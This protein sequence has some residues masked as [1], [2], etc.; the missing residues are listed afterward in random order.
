MSQH[1]FLTP[2]QVDHNMAVAPE[3]LVLFLPGT[4]AK[5]VS[6]TQLLRAAARAGHYVIGLAHLSQPITTAQSNAWCNSSVLVR[7]AEACNV[8]LHERL[9]F[10]SAPGV[11]GGE[12][13]GLWDVPAGE[14]VE[15][16]AVEALRSVEWGPTFL[17]HE[18]GQP[19]RVRWD[20]VIV[21]GHSQG[22]S[23]AAYVSYKT[24]SRTVLFSGPQECPA[25]AARWVQAMGAQH[26]SHRALFHVHEECGPHPKDPQSFCE[27]NL[28]LR[29][30]GRMGLVAPPWLWHAGASLPESLPALVASVA[31]PSCTKGRKYHCSVA[32]DRCA[33]LDMNIS[34][35][36]TALFSGLDA[37]SS[38]A[39]SSINELSLFESYANDWW[40][41]YVFA[42]I[43]FTLSVAVGAH[44]ECLRLRVPRGVQS[45]A[46]VYRH[47]PP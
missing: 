4:G 43:L 37:G 22:A 35:L 47:P 2:D 30:F 42:C 10:G 38:V 33:P 23:H 18:G 11:I 28:L 31:T 3:S 17:V 26:V 44:T 32:M 5:P 27:E 34:K 15:S 29:N 24:G 45:H 21:S 40:R 12:S 46:D 41:G 9:L 19:Y 36:W 13:S 25:C 16:L 14:D 1:V 20:L 6:Y 8:E 7:D 39:A